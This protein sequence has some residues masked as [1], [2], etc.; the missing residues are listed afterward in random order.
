MNKLSANTDQVAS[1]L[2]PKVFPNLSN[3]KLSGSSVSSVSSRAPFPDYSNV[4]FLPNEKPIPNLFQYNDR[5]KLIL[6]SD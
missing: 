2:P 5:E 6:S 3:F 4:K 1:S